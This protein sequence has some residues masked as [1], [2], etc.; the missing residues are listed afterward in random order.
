MSFAFYY[1]AV[2][3]CVSLY[4]RSNVV[5]TDHLYV[6]NVLPCG[7]VFDTQRYLV[8]AG[9]AKLSVRN[10]AGWTPLMQ[11]VVKSDLT[12]T[13]CGAPTSPL[14]SS[15]TQTYIPYATGYQ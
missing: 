3:V 1:L 11:A 5:Q 4:N 10:S 9:G 15:P 14:P 13:R 2:S 6:T 12:M 8:Q 7:G